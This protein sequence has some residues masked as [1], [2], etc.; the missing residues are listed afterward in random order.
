[1]DRIDV[2]I[3]AEDPLA[4][5]AI[6]NS[7]RQFPNLQVNV[8]GILGPDI[9]LVDLGIDFQ[10]SFNLYEEELQSNPVPCILLYQDLDFSED[11]NRVEVKFHYVSNFLMKPARYSEVRQDEGQDSEVVDNFDEENWFSK[12][13]DNMMVLVREPEKKWW[14]IRG[15]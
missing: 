7:L 12:S 14:I 10:P 9:L 4:A 5:K 13:D 11:R 1:M 6:E 2:R 3:L 15:M 8:P